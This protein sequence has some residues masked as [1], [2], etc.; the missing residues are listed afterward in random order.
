MSVS[1]P[2]LNM[3]ALT[4][5]ALTRRGVTCAGLLATTGTVCTGVYQKYIGDI[6]LLTPDE[7]GQA[8]VMDMIY[9][10]V[11]AGKQT[12]SAAAVQRVAER[13]LAKGAQCLILGCTELRWRWSGITSASRRWIPRWSWPEGP[14]FLPA[15]SSK[16][17]IRRMRRSL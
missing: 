4:G 12:Y 9:G 16:T 14:S 6:R 1:V 5:E 15:D 17:G 10:G 3:I 7:A 13:L 11:K 2:V 8:A